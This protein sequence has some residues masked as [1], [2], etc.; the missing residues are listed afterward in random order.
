MN[1]RENKYEYIV[2]EDIIWNEFRFN[3]WGSRKYKYV[4]EN[5]IKFYILLLFKIYLSKKGDILKNLGP[6]G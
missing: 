5:N 6:V 4:S 2:H 3:S 1:G